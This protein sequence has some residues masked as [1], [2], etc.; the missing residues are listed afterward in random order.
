MVEG[1][2]KQF[3]TVRVRD[4][5]LCV[6]SDNI[7]DPLTGLEARSSTTKWIFEGFP[8]PA[9][10]GRA[11]GWRFPFIQISYPDQEMEIKVVDRSKHLIEHEVVILCHSEDRQ[12]NSISGRLEASRL[13]DEVIYILT[14]TGAADLVKGSLNEPIEITS[15]GPDPDF[16][17]ARKFYTKT[18]TATFRRFD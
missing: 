4:V 14:V 17:R 12:S 1:V 9:N 15:S 3:E 8:N 5:I 18:V 7:S 2:I 10:L 16:I 11:D 6:I 13:A